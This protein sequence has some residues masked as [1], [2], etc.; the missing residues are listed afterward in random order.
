MENKTYQCE[1]CRKTFELKS[2]GKLLY[3]KYAIVVHGEAFV[4]C[5]ELCRKLGEKN[6]VTARE[7]EDILISLGKLSPSTSNSYVQQLISY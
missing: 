1:H 5:S 7:V 4:Y 6:I 3:P 2:K